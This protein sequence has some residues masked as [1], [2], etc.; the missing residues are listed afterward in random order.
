MISQAQQAI[1][2]RLASCLEL[3][4]DIRVGQL[5]SFLPI[6][7]ADDRRTPNLADMEDEELLQAL[8][9]HHRNLLARQEHAAPPT[10]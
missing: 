10:V 3:A 9:Q 6:I 2:E 7:A 8:E 4:E 5:V 1:L